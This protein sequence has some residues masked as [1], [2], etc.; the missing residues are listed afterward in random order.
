[1]Y[2]RGEPASSFTLVLQGHVAVTTGSENFCVDCGPWSYLGSR[3]LVEESFVCDYEAVVRDNA[4]LLHISMEDYRRVRSCLS[5]VIFL[6]S[7]QPTRPLTQ[8]LSATRRGVFQK[9][10][11]MP[12]AVVAHTS[13]VA[14]FSFHRTSIPTITL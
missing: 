7:H 8:A 9:A 12:Q 10:T 6:L 4:R 1:M 5:S 3:A 14:F 11:D 2:S 13:C